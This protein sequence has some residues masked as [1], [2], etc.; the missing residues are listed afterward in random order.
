MSS[1]LTPGGL[2]EVR[3]V[4]AMVS[5]S[6]GTIDPSCFLGATGPTG[7]TGE[8]GNY[9]TPA[10]L[11]YY[12]STEETQSLLNA[13]N[14]PVT[15]TN[16]DTIYSQGTTGLRYSAGNFRNESTTDDI[17]LNVAGFISFS[18][19][20]VGIRAVYGQINGAGNKFGYSQ[21]SSSSSGDTVVPFSFNILIN[22]FQLS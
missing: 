13:A 3:R 4:K 16:L 11:G 2:L 5:G 19:S 22:I 7:P 21:L 1:G 6:A 8:I 18:P 10:S 20:A 17:L 15:W 14:T 9:G 12:N